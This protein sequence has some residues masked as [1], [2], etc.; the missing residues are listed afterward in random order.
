MV[1][2]LRD[3][4]GVEARLLHPVARQRDDL[5]RIR[6]RK[7]AARSEGELVELRLRAVREPRG[8]AGEYDVVDEGRLAGEGVALDEV[9]RGGIHDPRLAGGPARDEQPTLV[10]DLQADR[11][12]AGALKGGDFLAGAHI[13][14]VDVAVY[15]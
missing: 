10:V 13:E 11:G 3:A 5:D 15:E 6:P 1:R 8:V 9:T 4:V 14:D 12:R 2:G 7:R